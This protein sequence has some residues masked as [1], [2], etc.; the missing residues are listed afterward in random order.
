MCEPFTVEI[1]DVQQVETQAI[2]C[3]VHKTLVQHFSGKWRRELT[4]NTAKRVD[5]PFFKEPVRLM[6]A[7]MTGGGG[8]KLGTTNLPYPKLD[9]SKL[10]I[11]RNVARYLE[12]DSLPE[13]ITKDIDAATPILPTPKVRIVICYFCKRTG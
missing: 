1:G 7:W 3:S 12:I 2:F 6:V 4:G 8:N 13:L 5:I 9:L 11:L 10:V